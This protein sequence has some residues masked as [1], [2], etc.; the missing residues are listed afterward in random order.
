MRKFIQITSLLSLVLTLAVFSAK[1]ST[2]AETG[3]GTEV[4]IPFAFN[5]GDKTYEAGDYIVRVQK[6]STGAAILSI[7][8]P[9]SDKAQNVILNETGAAGGSTEVKLVFENIN[10][11]R[12]LSKVTAQDRTFALVVSRDK[13]N[14]GSLAAT[15]GAANLF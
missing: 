8:D 6:L 4:N 1:A 15:G 14:A 11:Q 10:G 5:V 12:Q 2:V 3:F 9:D 7:Q 13:K